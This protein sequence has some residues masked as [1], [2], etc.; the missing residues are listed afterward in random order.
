MVAEDRTLVNGEIQYSG[1]CLVPLFDSTLSMTS[2]KEVLWDIILHGTA[3]VV[4][5]VPCKIM[6]HKNLFKVF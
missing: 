3:S 4:V 1:L 6:S 2:M 5:A